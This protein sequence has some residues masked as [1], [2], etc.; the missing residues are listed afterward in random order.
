MRS[1]LF[2]RASVRLCC[3]AAVL[4]SPHAG[5]ARAQGEADE[6]LPPVRAITK[7]PKHHWFGYYDKWQFDPTDRYVLGMEVDFEHRSPRPGDVI[8][9]GMVDLSDGDRWIELG[10]SRAWGWQ[11]GC[12]LQ[13]LPGS[14]SRIVWNDRQGGRFVCHV[15]DVK[16]RRKRTIPRAVYTISPD[17]RVGVAPDFARVQDMRPGYGYAGVPDPHA[18]ELAPADSGIWRIDMKTGEAKVIVSLADIARFGKLDASMRGAKHYFNHL[19]FAPDGKRFIFLHRWRPDAGRGGFRTRM[20]TA[21]PDG[22]D[23]RVVDPSGHTSHF[24][25]RDGGH[26]LAWTRPA[27]KPSAFYLFDET[28]GTCE[29]VGQGVMTANG[30]CTYLPLG[31][32]REWILND[33]Y[34]RG[35]GRGQSPYLFHVPTGRR[36]WLGHFHLPRE[37]RGEWRCDTHPRFSRDGTKVCIDSPHGGGGRQL[38]LI[39]VRGIVRAARGS[40]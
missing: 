18:K 10:D 36:F 4:C 19:L 40:R 39:D 15:L 7:G 6:K 17:G 24:I 25:W 14:R 23:V 5:P 32:G 26:I 28:T 13:W 37:Y 30:H 8:R 3:L 31:G 33:T 2:R 34:P 11:Q 16:T 9:I 35:K 20:L 21:T 29:Q 38:W 27:G 22:R 12:M 1:S